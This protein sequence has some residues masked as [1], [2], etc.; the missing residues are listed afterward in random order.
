MKRL[1]LFSL[2]FPN[3]KIRK[4]INQKREELGFVEWFPVNELEA[5]YQVAKD[6]DIDLSVYD[7]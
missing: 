1:T 7:V 4:M 5:G 6:L 3:V 2:G